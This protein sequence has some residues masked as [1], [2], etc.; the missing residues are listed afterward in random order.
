MRFSQNILTIGCECK[1]PRGGI[2]YVLHTYMNDIFSP[3]K[4]VANSGEG[5]K[6]AKV[7][8][9]L[10]AYVKCEVRERQDKD[11]KVVHIHTASNN[12]F[13]R[14]TLF[15]RQAKRLGKHVVLHIHGG[16]FREYYK[17][18]PK[19]VDKHLQ[20]C[21]A[22]IALSETWRHFFEDELGYEQTYIVNNVIP[23]PQP[24]HSKQDNRTH[25]LFLGL[26]TEEKGIFDL[27]NCIHRHSKEW[28]GK[29]VL[30]VGGNGKTNLLVEE[31][32]R[33]RLED[34]VY[35]EGWVSG[36]QKSRLLSEADAFILPSYTEGLPISILE[37]MS[38]GLPVLATPVGGIP[39]IIQQNKQGLLFTP[40]DMDMME[41][42]I[43]QIINNPAQAKMMG[44][45]G[46]SDI[47]NFLPDKTALQLENIYSHILQQE[48]I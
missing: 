39:E 18:S 14:S 10:R 3:F 38:Y 4:F 26:I 12:C 48:N 19:F 22:I 32:K 31:I 34:I 30:H 25:L 2:A 24:V 29:L 35:F 7:W 8:Q 15:I 9:M 43:R 21:D 33:L 5:G 17:S 37:A 47:K 27:L 41:R 44:Q 11:L 1:K 20:M 23:I 45:Q 28:K 46:K 6:I 36:S 40:G 42:A 13:R 16:A